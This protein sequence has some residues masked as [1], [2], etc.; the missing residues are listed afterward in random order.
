MNY[1]IVNTK[2]FGLEVWV[3]AFVYPNGHMVT[4]S[5]LSRPAAYT[6]CLQH[7]NVAARTTHVQ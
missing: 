2:K 4:S 6:W 5:F 7:N 1:R 3:A